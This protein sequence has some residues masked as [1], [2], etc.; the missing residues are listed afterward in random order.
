MDEF[1]AAEAAKYLG[2]TRE[3]VDAAARDGRLPAVAGDGPRRFSREAVEGYHQLK[4]DAIVALLARTHETPV[5][6]AAKVRTGLHSLSDT[7]LP[8]SHASKLAVMPVN[9]R[10]LFN[11]AELAAASV[12]DGEGCR[13][14]RAVEYSAFLGLRPL[15][16]A[17]ARVELF[18]AEPCEVCGPAL[19]R[20]FMEALS[21]RVHRGAPRPPER[22]S[23]PSEAD[24]KAAREWAQEHAVTAAAKP[25]KDDGGRALVAARLREVRARAKLAKRAGD[26]KYALKLAQMARD[27]ER[28]AAVVDG[29][30]FSATDRPGTLRCGHELA[31][32]CSCPRRA[33][34]RGQR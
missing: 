21:A 26:Q 4:Q 29:R 34:T 16:F 9:W 15:E 8:R 30:A 24:R 33:S 31:A 1:S 5:S 22:P 3:A 27:L 20:P 14:C 12:P 11:R 25:V 19:L 32:R 2:V 13:W 7:G 6:V 28:D 10:A 23:P 18:G 17:P